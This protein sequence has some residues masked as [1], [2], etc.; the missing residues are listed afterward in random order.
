MKNSFYKGKMIAAFKLDM[1]LG[2]T[3]NLNSI[4]K[5]TFLG[6]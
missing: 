6:I 1:S 5:I 3:L 2:A 4:I